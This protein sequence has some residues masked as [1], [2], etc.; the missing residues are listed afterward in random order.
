MTDF[1]KGIVAIIILVLMVVGFCVAWSKVNQ[2]TFKEEDYTIKTIYVEEGDSLYTYYY[3]YSKTGCEATE[4]CN[5]I[6]D[7][8][9][10]RNS[11]IYANTS[12]KVYVAINP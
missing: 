3:R 1:G 2:P 8:N 4:Y 12:I 10:M 9:N 11:T 7:L 5:A 6:K